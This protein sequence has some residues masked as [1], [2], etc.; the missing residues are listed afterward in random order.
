METVATKISFWLNWYLPDLYPYM[1]YAIEEL[2]RWSSDNWEVILV[3]T[4][5]LS[6]L[7]VWAYAKKEVTDNKIL[8][9][10]IHFIN[11]LLYMVSFKWL[12]VVREG[13]K[14]KPYV[15]TDEVKQGEVK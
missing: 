8:S 1:R 14:Q 2:F 12:Q 13:T 11:F 15:L 3:A 7:K 5:V 9:L 10:F 6:A 4:N